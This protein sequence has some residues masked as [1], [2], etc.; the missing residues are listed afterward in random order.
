VN[1]RPPDVLVWQTLSATA[2][3]FDDLELSSISDSGCCPIPLADDAA[4]EFDSYPVRLYAK[5]PEKRF[6]VLAVGDNGSLAIY[7]NFNRLWM[8]WS[9][10]RFNSAVTRII[11]KVPAAS[12][13]NPTTC[14]LRTQRRTFRCLSKF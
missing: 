1:R 6:D 2:D 10:G 5:A 13:G 9:S 11:V 4:I 8:H 3:E 12:R 14:Q 7:R